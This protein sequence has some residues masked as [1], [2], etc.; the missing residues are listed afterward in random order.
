MSFEP[1]DVMNLIELAY[2]YRINPL[3][4]FCG[5]ILGKNVGDENV[6]VLLNLS[7]KYECKSLR[8]ASANH[9]AKSFDKMLENGL[10]MKYEVNQ[11]K[12]KF[13]MIDN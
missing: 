5:E 1:T 6:Q 10:I 7:T 2:H 13:I 4:E 11:I 3:V 8:T 12:S 9:L